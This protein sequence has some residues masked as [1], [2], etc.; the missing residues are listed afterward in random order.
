MC[1]RRISLGGEGN[2]SSL[3]LFF[4]HQTCLLFISASEMTYTV[5]GGALNSVQPQPAPAT[6]DQYRDFSYW[7][8]QLV[9]LLNNGI[10][11]FW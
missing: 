8:E 9:Q 6:V 5:S 4:D 2:A 3:F 11:L 7:D 10:W 1:V